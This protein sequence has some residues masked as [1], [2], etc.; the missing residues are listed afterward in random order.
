MRNR[1]FAARICGFQFFPAGYLL[2]AAHQVFIQRDVILLDEIGPI[3]FD[4]PRHVFAKVLARF[5][6]EVAGALEDFIAHLIG[7]IAIAPAK[8]AAFSHFTQARI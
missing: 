2:F 7:Q 4:K 3:T 5:G 6:H 1:Q 8:L